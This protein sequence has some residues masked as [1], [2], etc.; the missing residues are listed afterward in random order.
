L[1]SFYN[2]KNN[3]QVQQNKTLLVLKGNINFIRPFA[4]F[5]SYFEVFEYSLYVTPRDEK[6]F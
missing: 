6:R 5:A 1:L 3:N 4:H 2:K